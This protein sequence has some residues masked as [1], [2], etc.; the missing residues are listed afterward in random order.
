MV[1]D[2]LA[3]A[4]PVH[5]Q[6]LV[7]AAH[8]AEIGFSQLLLEAWQTLPETIQAK[9]APR[10]ALPSYSTPL[11]RLAVSIARATLRSAPTEA[12]RANALNTLGVRLSAQGDAASRT[13]ALA[14][15]R[16]AGSILASLQALR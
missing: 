3:L 11:L 8:T 14:R 4:W 16:E 1:R 5:G 12:A 2:G 6:V 9:I 7:D 10:L 15:A 13:E